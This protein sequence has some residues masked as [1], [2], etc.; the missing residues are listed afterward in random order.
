M[1]IINYSKQCTITP[2]TDSRWSGYIGV[3]SCPFIFSIIV[4]HKAQNILRLGTN[5][6]LNTYSKLTKY[7]N[8]N[9]TVTIHNMATFHTTIHASLKVMVIQVVN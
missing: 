5:L 9:I 2:A 3:I 7:T 6:T 1:I 4:L 8:K